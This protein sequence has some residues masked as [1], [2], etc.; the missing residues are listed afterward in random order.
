[1]QKN[2]EYVIKSN[3]KDKTLH[4]PNEFVHDCSYHHYQQVFSC[5]MDS[6]I[7]AILANL[8]MEHIEERALTTAPHPPKWWYQFVNNSH[9][10]IYKQFIEEFPSHLNSID[11]HIH[12]SYD[13]EQEDTSSFLDTNTT[14][15]TDGSITITAYRKPTNT[16]KYLDFDSYDHVQHKRAVARTLLDRG[17]CIPFTDKEKNRRNT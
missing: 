14:R 1:M 2:P 17:N 4:C 8:F 6:P 3:L 7:F 16:D 9:A 13:V 12:F 11:P 5:R 15:Q 10:C